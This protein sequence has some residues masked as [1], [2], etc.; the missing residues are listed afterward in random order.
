[1]NLVTFGNFSIYSGLEFSI[2]ACAE[3]KEKGIRFHY[4]IYTDDINNE[5][6][7]FSIYDFVFK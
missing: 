5:M 2:H 3:L 6:I 4:T 1:M 7:L